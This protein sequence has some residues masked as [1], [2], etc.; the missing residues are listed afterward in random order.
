MKVTLVTLFTL[1]ALLTALALPAGLAAQAA[2]CEPDGDVRFICNQQA[3]EDLVVVP[4]G[5]WV[6]ASSYAGSGGIRLIH[7]RDKTSTVAYP[8]AAPVDRQDAKTYSACPGPPD[9]KSFQTHG[10]YL[11]EGRNSVHRLFAVHHGP[12]ESVEVFEVNATGKTPALTWIGC[13]VAPDPIGLNEVVGLPDGG[14]FATN[15]L[16]RGAEAATARGRLMAGENNGELWEWRPGA[17]WKMIPGSEASGANGL[18]VSKDGRWLYVAAWGSQSLFRLSRG[19]TPPKKEEV[20]LGFRAD[21]VRW[22]PDGSLFVAGQSLGAGA[23]QASVVVKVDPNTLQ[24]R[25]IIR[26]PNSASFS[27]GTVAIQVGKEIWVGSFRGDRIAVF[28]AP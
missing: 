13:A 21:N 15:F 16:Q 25:E 10:L 20:K 28:P 14:F 22:A 11:L 23:Q 9:K 24:V 18:E 2:P 12:R 1:L 7:V 26:R 3:P 8:G 6:F 19:E 4:G 5:E 27:N 17:G